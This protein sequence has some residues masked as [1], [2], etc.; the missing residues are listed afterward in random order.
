MMLPIASRKGLVLSFHPETS[1][2]TWAMGDPTR[3][4]RIVTNLIGNAIKY[5]ESGS[6][7][8]SMATIPGAEGNFYVNLDVADTGIGIAPNKLDMVFDKFVQADASINRRYGGSGL[9]LA[10]TKQLVEMMHGEITV[11]STVNVGTTFTVTIPFKPTSAT[12]ENAHTI[13]SLVACGI[14]PAADVRIL[15]AEDHILNQAYLKK[16]LPSLEIGHFLLVEN[17]LDAVAAYKTGKF[18]IILMDCHMP[19]M[20]GYDATRAIRLYEMGTQHHIPI[21]AMTANAMIHE[22]EKC[23]E[24]GMDEYLSKPIS[25]KD[26]LVALSPWVKFSITAISKIN[27][28]ME[29]VIPSVLDLT[30]LRSYSE[31]NI[32]LE[33]EFVLTFIEQA[34]QHMEQ[35]MKH[36]V[37]G[38]ST[39]WRDAAHLLKGGAAMLGAMQLKEICAAAQEMLNTSL[40]E[41]SRILE[42]IVAAY[43]E[44]LSKLRQHNLFLGEG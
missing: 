35:L 12:H 39:E 38:E 34:T 5:T 20:T 26:F 9:G 37:D 41:R 16:L 6:V 7:R 28:K 21:I 19:G 1:E 25:K 11:A 32:H 43:Q 33:R 17:G 13:K 44:V 2:P 22:R 8:A 30:I 4:A 29:P 14:I 15:C 42:K 36:C 27:S 18:D 40:A 23:L 10:I 24:C 3:Y 31:N